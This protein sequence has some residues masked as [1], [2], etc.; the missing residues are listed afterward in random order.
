MARPK[1]ASWRQRALPGEHTAPRRSTRAQGTA[2]DRVRAEA[3]AP[4]RHDGRSGASAV[5]RGS[6]R[7]LQAAATQL[8]ATLRSVR[9]ARNRGP[10]GGSGP[11]VLGARA[12]RTSDEAWGRGEGPEARG[13]HEAHRPRLAAHGRVSGDDN[14]NVELQ[15]TG[16]HPPRH[17]AR[18]H[19][20]VEGDRRSLGEG[21]TKRKSPA[22]PGFFVVAAEREKG[23]EPSTSTLA[24]RHPG[25]FGRY[26]SL[27]VARN[28]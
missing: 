21:G 1:N 7:V 17:R 8:G 5:R 16:G 12:L 25:V 18:G 9:S 11:D 14:P 19:H 13:S 28:P 20:Q 2:A 26:G 10:A 3:P 6:G 15:F 24:R 4:R 22:E 27:Q 23:F